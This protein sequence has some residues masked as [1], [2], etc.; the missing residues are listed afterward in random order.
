MAM[1]HLVDPYHF[2]CTLSTASRHLAEA[3]A[4]NSKP[5]GFYEIVPIA[6]HD[7]IDIFSNMAFDVLPQHWK[8]DHTIE[9]ECKC[10]PGFRKVYPMMLTKQQEIDTLIEEALATSCYKGTSICFLTS[11]LISY[12]P[13][14]HMYFPPHLCTISRDHTQSWWL[15]Y[16]KS[17]DFPD[18][19]SLKVVD[20]LPLPLLIPQWHQMCLRCIS[21]GLLI[22]HRHRIHM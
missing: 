5:K 22:C 10:S 7:Y 17:D 9:L 2:I 3:S 15:S 19:D 20:F 13:P 21:T 12:S 1:V 6:L 11:P 8:W 18:I 4:K 14:V 16:S